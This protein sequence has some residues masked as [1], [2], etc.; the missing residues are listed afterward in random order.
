MAALISQRLQPRDR[1]WRTQTPLDDG[2]FADTLA[3]A[4]GLEDWLL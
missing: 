1:D 2:D 4:L 3:E